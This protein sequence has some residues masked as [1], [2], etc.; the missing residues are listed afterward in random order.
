MKNECKPTRGLIAIIEDDDELRDYFGEVVERMPGLEL[1]WTSP[2]ITSARAMLGLRVDLV[3][4]DIGLPDGSGL[5]MIGDLKATGAKVLVVT[6]LGDQETVVTAIRCGADGYLLKDSSQETIWEGINVTLDGGAPISASAAV[7]VLQQIRKPA[8][9][10]KSS[11]DEM[12]ELS[13]REIDLLKVFALGY[14]YKE[15]ARA[16]G[17]SPLTVGSH[18]KSIYRKLAVH[19]RTEAVFSAVK[20]GKI[21]L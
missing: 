19:T 20:S 15:A 8:E 6:S 13:E 17:I 7:F 9:T 2:D 11:G 14:S 10:T 3:L 12:D 5:D 16:L 18:V 4:L 21:S 1:A